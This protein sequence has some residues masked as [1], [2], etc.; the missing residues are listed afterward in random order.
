MLHSPP[1]QVGAPCSVEHASLQAPQ[2]ASAVFRFTSQPFDASWSQSSNPA[3][4]PPFSKSIEQVPPE[5]LAATALSGSQ[6]SPQAPQCATSVFKF[7]SQ[8]S[9]AFPL[10]SSWP[11]GHTSVQ[12]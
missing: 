12:R 2:C 1:M 10:Q 5:H 8:P 7:T 6:T 11:V 4:Q 9:A 3:T